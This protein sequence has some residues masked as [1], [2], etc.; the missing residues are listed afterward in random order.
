VEIKD[1]KSREGRSEGTR[2]NINIK[3]HEA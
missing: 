3:E 1:L 2:V